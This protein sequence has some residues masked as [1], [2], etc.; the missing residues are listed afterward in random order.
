MTARRHPD[1]ELVK[2][3][4]RGWSHVVAC[5]ATL[6]AAWALV[7]HAHTPM[8]QVAAGE[9]GVI[10]FLLFG[11]SASYHRIEWSE[12]MLGFMRRLDHGNIFITIA[13]IYTAFC[14]ITLPQAS[15]VPSLV[16]LWAGAIAGITRVLLWPYAPRWI[17]TGSYV[18]ASVIA[19]PWVGDIERH[20]P[21][22]GVIWIT[23]GFVFSGVGGL[24]YATGRPEPWP[25]V[26]GH[27]EVF[28]LC[29]VGLAV[30]YYAAL[31]LAM[32]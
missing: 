29:V 1:E 22:A 15:V 24:C 32:G 18:L 3:L 13:G 11:I 2:P 30:S 26:F 20:M 27:H 7:A 25:D 14:L 8:Q 12:R 16:T 5:V 21:T 4:L 19:A 17:A 31:W 6:P 28:H 23:A 10:F 9:L